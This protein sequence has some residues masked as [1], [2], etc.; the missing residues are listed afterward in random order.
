MTSSGDSSALDAIAR[1]S[2]SVVNVS[3]VRQMRDVYFRPIPLKG[4]GSGVVIR[5]DG[6]IL[7]NSHVIQGADNISVTFHDGRILEGKLVGAS[8]SLDIAVIKVK[9][10]GLS[11]ADFGSSEEL[12]VGQRVF[13]IG[14]PFGLPGG[15]T[16]TSGVVSALGRTINSEFGTLDD[17]IQTDAAINPGNSGGPLI[18]EGGKVIAINTAI[19]P[20]AQGIGFAIP[21]KVAV[22]CSEDII[23]HGKVMIPWLGINGVSVNAAVAR[24]YNL[25]SDAG[26]LVLG[27]VEGSPAYRADITAGDVIVDFRGTPVQSIE[28]LRRSIMASKAGDSVELSILRDGEKFDV[29]VKLMAMP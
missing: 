9:A 11:E 12:R 7:T 13:A 10:Q 24:R 16:V 8:P 25:A 4:M 15:P 29:R 27:V 23:R 22:R 21:Q 5:S 19:I 18:D 1:V 6:Y 20:F 17:L 28:G 3:T 26:V 2:K 14:N